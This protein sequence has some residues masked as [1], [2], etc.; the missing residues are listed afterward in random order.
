[1]AI[2]HG[3]GHLAGTF[4]HSQPGL[5]D[6]AEAKL[7]FGQAVPAIHECGSHGRCT[8]GHFTLSEVITHF[9]KA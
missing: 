2:G 3:P 1:M 5:P 7:G 8:L 4:D 6:I 9:L